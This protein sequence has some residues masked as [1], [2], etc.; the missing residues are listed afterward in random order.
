MIR[1]QSLKGIR[2]VSNGKFYN[3]PGSAVDR[4]LIIKIS[5]VVSASIPLGEVGR[6]SVWGDPLMSCTPFK[7][8]AVK[9]V[10]AKQFTKLP[11][12]KVYVKFH[13]IHVLLKG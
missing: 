3:R 9:P 2:E 13:F 12:L 1:N 5:S 7:P 10:W 6:V 4:L 8:K 11:G